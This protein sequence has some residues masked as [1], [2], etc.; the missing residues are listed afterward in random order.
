MCV[1]VCVSASKCKTSAKDLL[2]VVA[3]H[4]ATVKH[5]EEALSQQKSLMEKP[6]HRLSDLMTSMRNVFERLPQAPDPAPAPTPATSSA[7]AVPPL[8]E[9]RLPLP[10]RFSGNTE[11][12]EGF[13]TQCSLT[14]QLQPSTFPSDQARIAYVLILLA[15]KALAWA[16]A[17]W[18][19][20]AP[21]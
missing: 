19:A 11:A 12:C 18:N 21:C 15:G 6:S 10:Q 17:V 14:F 20:Q 9:P 4:E 16:T 3:Q 5:H 7:G 1:C 8:V 13:L 2:E